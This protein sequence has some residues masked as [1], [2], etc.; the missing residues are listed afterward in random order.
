[1][2]H[3]AHPHTEGGMLGIPLLQEGEMVTYPLLASLPCLGA[4][5]WRS[6]YVDS[7]VPTTPLRHW[8]GCCEKVACA[9]QA[10][11]DPL[12]MAGLE[13]TEGS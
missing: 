2:S 8:G 9:G 7:M 12:G 11:G 5:L 13:Y 6:P 10:G 1:M 4:S 3:S